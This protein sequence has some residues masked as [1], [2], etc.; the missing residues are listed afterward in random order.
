MA[1]LRLHNFKTT[2]RELAHI[3]GRG[4]RSGIGVASFE[5]GGFI[6]E[7]GH[8]KYPQ[9]LPI[10]PSAV[11]LRRDFPINWRFVIVIVDTDP[12]LSGQAESEAF[13]SLDNTQE[14]TD[15][16][17]RIVQLRLLPAL[18]E[19][20]IEAFGQAVSEVDRQTGLFFR[21]AQGGVYR[22]GADQFVEKLLEAGAYG[23][24]QSSWGP[25]LYALVDDA[26][27]QRVLDSARS[28]MLKS[29]KSGQI[30]VPRARNA[31]ADILVED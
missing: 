13:A 16:I 31:G 5:S 22:D 20:D 26:N 11:I 19:E 28:F 27:E 29:G 17:C 2:A 21:K 9:S 15:R 10:V 14:V 1:L 12:G 18:I 24:G 25:C 4:L 30:F 6:L 8:K 3:M 7:A 23:V